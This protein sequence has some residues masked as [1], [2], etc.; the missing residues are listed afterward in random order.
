MYQVLYRKYRPK[1]F[2]DVCGQQVVVKLLKNSIKNNKISHAYLFAGPRG[3]GKT[4]MA[5]IFAKVVNCDNLVDLAPCDNCINCNN[6]SNDV[7]EIDAASNNGV[8]EIREIRNKVNLVPTSGKYKI[9]IIDEVH[10][11]TTGAFNALLKT[12]EEPPAHVIF[13]LATTDPHKIPETILSRCQRLDFKRIPVENIV[14]KLAEIAK[15]EN[16]NVDDNVLKE[17]A[18]LSDGGLRDSISLLDEASIFS[19]GNPSAE[20]IHMINGTISKK[21]IIGFVSNLNK[22]NYSLVFECVENYNSCGKNFLKLTE[23][24]IFCLKDILIYLIAP[25]Y[26]KDNSEIECEIKNISREM[27]K[28]KLMKYIKEF[29]YCYSE[30]GKTNDYKLMFEL[31]IVNLLNSDEGVLGNIS[32]QDENALEEKKMLKNVENSKEEKKVFEEES[33]LPKDEKKQPEVN[34]KMLSY[35]R[36]IRIDNT[37]AHFDKKL[38]VNL[39][40]QL[41]NITGFLLE[42]SYSHFVSI[43][44]DGTLKASSEN[45]L[46]FVFSKKCISD[47]FNMNLVIIEEL[48]EQLFGKHFD[49]I[50]TWNDE[51]EIVKSDFNSKKK[52]YEYREEKFNLNE[53]LMQKEIKNDL[54]NLFG[55]IIEYN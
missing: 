41:E 25:D 47:D 14:L 33:S 30:M 27:S 32:Q 11:L 12:L 54:T 26:F 45:N 15:K 42:P 5:K 7:I 40:K 18:R 36:N 48:L 21:E 2:D 3:T 35:L 1:T 53:F 23:E 29:N 55:D 43:I 20:D 16:I 9:Y 37:L 24:I 13:I 44:M 49:A 19:E 8:D 38:L 52:K 46:I 28:E 22:N 51:W 6:N 39:K 50:S 17:I 4:S 31:S 34:D 10:M